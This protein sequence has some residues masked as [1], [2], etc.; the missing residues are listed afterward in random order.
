MSAISIHDLG[1][2]NAVSSSEFNSE[3]NYQITMSY[4]RQLRKNGTVTDEEYRKI[5]TIMLK[6]YRPILGTL[7]SGNSLT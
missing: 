5:D 1:R 4:V 2:Y 3:M 6:K 7:L